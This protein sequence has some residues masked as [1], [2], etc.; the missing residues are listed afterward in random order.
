MVD[1]VRLVHQLFQSL[2][3]GLS[4]LHV[5]LMAKPLR[6]R[7]ELAQLLVGVDKDMMCE[8]VETV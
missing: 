8:K 7:V 5:D 2:R 3:H 6:K 4:A 1:H